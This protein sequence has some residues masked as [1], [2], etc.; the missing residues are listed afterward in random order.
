M[1]GAMLSGNLRVVSSGGTTDLQFFRGKLA[2]SGNPERPRRLGQ[3]LL[4]RGLLDRAALEEAL[5]FQQDFA[6]GTPLGKVLVFRE[7]IS[8]GD[9]EAALRLQLEEE[10]WDLLSF[11]EGTWTFIEGTA[12]AEEL[13]LVQVDAIQLVDQAMDR[14]REWLDI[15]ERIPSDAVIPAVV[16]MGGISDREV[17]HFDER[18][19]LVLSL[20][21]GYYDASCIAA[22]SGLGRFETYRILAHLVG[23]GVVEL[24]MPAEPVVLQTS[25]EELSGQPP[26]SDKGGSSASR[27]SGI[28]A[29]IRD[30]EEGATPA[31]EKG[32]LHFGSPVSF[33]VAI[34]T[35]VIHQLMQNPDF[36]VDPSDERLAERY[37]RQILMA[38]PKADLVVAESNKLDAGNFDRYIRTLGVQGPM[39]SIYLE[40]MDGLGRFLRTLYLLAVQ[41]LGSKAARTLFVSTMDDLRQ[42]SSMDNSESF[43]FKEFAAKV[44]E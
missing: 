39:R 3:I 6:P 20:V 10:V 5:A 11:E 25:A 24:R 8:T 42:R 15:K 22:R 2:G 33:V 44:L 41:R 32:R 9:L 37:W 38:Y 31:I 29:R 23:S 4:S 43:F 35:A 13:P 36:V 16:R 1:A 26:A 17:L 19:W 7:R 30:A 14:R 27:W 18:E 34:G 21:N 12:E 40:T 28:L